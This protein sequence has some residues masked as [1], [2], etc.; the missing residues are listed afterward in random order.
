MVDEISI[1]TTT[2]GDQDQPGVAALAGTQ[3]AVVWT[4]HGTGNI[5]CRLLG[6]NAAP[7]SD[8]FTV[9][10][11]APPGTKRRL[12]AVIETGPGLAV[13]WIEELPGAAPQLK[14]RT[15][16]QDTL[17]G[18]ESQVSTAEIEPLI[19]PALARLPDG[20]FIIVWADARPDE[21]IR[22]QR[23]DIDGVKNGAEFRANTFPGLHRVPMVAS[24]TNGNI[25]IGWRARTVSPLLVRLQVF[26]AT[27]GAV[28]AEVTTTLNITEAAM[29]ALDGGRFAI[30]SV[31]SALDG[32]PGFD[33]T[34]PK[35]TVFEASG[36]SANINFPA[37]SAGR[38]Q[39]S[40]PALAPLSGGRFLL[41]WTQV[42]VD[43][44]AAGTNVAARIFSVQGPVGQVVQVNT[45][46]GGQ[47]FSLSAAAAP[48]PSGDT[49]F[50]A[51]AD[52]GPAGPDT[53]G[54]A[55]QG[56]ALSIP[57]GGF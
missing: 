39:S 22:A 30:A 9:N 21:R 16:N 29:I 41:A 43:N 42:N 23:Y 37:T 36:A 55:I 31:R 6:V 12:P 8:E 1:N 40:W 5:K 38:I 10:F 28:G 48:G 19:R 34:V 13:A 54:R 11:P 7:T 45:L 33:T 2:A 4:D 46:T 18:P 3:F 24:L 44:P 49:A 57:A 15:L 20:G 32:E 25:V 26:G 50:F 51:W 35:L 17:S 47:R 14:L 56:R 52:D 53:S 27:G